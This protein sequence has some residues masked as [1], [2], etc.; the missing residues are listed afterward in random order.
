[1]SLFY[2]FLM[3]AVV[4]LSLIWVFSDLPLE[5]ARAIIVNQE[6]WDTLM[7]IGK[8]LGIG[9]VYLIS[10]TV[11]EAINRNNSRKTPVSFSHKWHEAQRSKGFIVKAVLTNTMFSF[12]LTAGKFGF[13]MIAGELDPKPFLYLFSSQLLPIFLKIVSVN[14]SESELQ[15]F[16][17]TARDRETPHRD[18]LKPDRSAPHSAVEKQDRENLYSKEMK[19]DRSEPY[20][21][22]EKQDREKLYRGEMK[23]LPDP[24]EAFR[25]MQLPRPVW[26]FLIIFIA[27]LFCFVTIHLASTGDVAPVI[28]GLFFLGVTGVAV[29]YQ[30]CKYRKISGYRENLKDK[31]PDVRRNAVNGL[32]DILKEDFDATGK[33]TF[34]LLEAMRDNDPQVRLAAAEICQRFYDKTMKIGVD[35]EN[36][37]ADTVPILPDEMKPAIISVFINALKDEYAPVRCE[38]AICLGKSRAAEAILPLTDALNDPDSEV[39]G[40]VIRALE[41]LKAPLS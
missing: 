30:I 4:I 34:L 22:V 6:D 40:H 2:F 31:N 36:S 15:F 18:E 35:S 25:Q 12:V 32:H 41:N 26:I 8:V 24:A 37:S 28:F 10:F 38:A 23:P 19:P 11:F 27:L 29:L 9:L 5:L 39:R 20:S 7:N 17:F 14:C 21:A 13:S 16:G 3:L 33:I 1:V